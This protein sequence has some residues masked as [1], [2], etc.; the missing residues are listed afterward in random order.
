MTDKSTY[1]LMCIVELTDFNFM[2]FIKIN[3]FLEKKRRRIPLKNKTHEY[4]TNVN[5]CYT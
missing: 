5:N 2:K 4:S 3:N 1:S